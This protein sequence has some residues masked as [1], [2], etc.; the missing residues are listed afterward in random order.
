MFLC[1]L[2]LLTITFFVYKFW[3][4]SGEA[5]SAKAHPLLKPDWK[6]DVVYI[7][8]FPISPS[9]CTYKMVNILQMQLFDFLL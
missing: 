8:Q 3:R 1:I 2:A 9:V 5:N 7:V 4:N 6:K